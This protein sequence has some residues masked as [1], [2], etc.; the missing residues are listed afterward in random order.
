[1]DKKYRYLIVILLILA[2]LIA[3]GRI[4][5]NGFIDY[6]DPIYLTKNTHV[7][8]GLN[9]ESIQ[10]AFT[11]VVCSNWHPLTLLSHT[12]DWTLFK[13]NAGGHHLVSLFLHIGAVLLLFFFLYKTTKN[14]W[15][16]AFAAALF[17]LHPLRVESVAWAAERKDV[18]SIF[19]GLASIYAYASYAESRRLSRYLFCLVFFVLSLMSKPMLVTLPFL[20]LLIDYW[21][22]RR[23]QKVLNSAHQQAVNTD[24]LNPNPIKVSRRSISRLLWEKV[25]FIFLTIVSSMATLRAQSQAFP[26][27]LP[28][29]VRVVNAIIS[30]VSYLEKIFWPAD[31]AVFYPYKNAFLFMPAMFSLLFLIGITL[32]VVYY[33]KKMPFLFV[34]W[35]WYLGTLIPVIGLVQVGSQALADRYT[36]LPSVGIAMMLA[37]GIPFWVRGKDMRKKILFPAGMMILVILAFLTWQQ[38]GYWKNNFTLFKHALEVTE[39]NDL[40]HN[41]MGIAL[42]NEGKIDEAIGHYDRAIQIKPG[43]VDAYANRGNAYAKLGRYQRAIEDYNQ[44]ILLKPDFAEGYY[45]RGNIRSIL[46]QYQLALEDYDKAISLNPDYIKTYNNRGIIYG[47]LGQYQRAIEIFNTVIRL[48]PDYAYAYYNR[49]FAYA[50]LDQHEKAI[51]DFDRAI[52]LKSDYMKA[53]YNRGIAYAKL[54]RYRQATKDFQAVIRL[55]PDDENARQALR[56]A[57]EKQRRE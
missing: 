28:F 30:Y 34:G 21:P 35:F 14:I 19:F 1:M 51:D 7:K 3:F 13:D 42:L 45:S 46:G 24:M 29:P 44:A 26:I 52:S 22:L 49:G 39:D 31:L 16:S 33:F 32:G 53:Y 15:P 41:N 11:A 20:L 48:Q 50:R 55:R 10:W 2:S 54:G 47:E 37:W 18:L 9:P 5:G 23:W 6:D 4:A 36:Y 43:Y 25:P 38:C 27:H 8:S 40:A 57:L 56:L 17:A 12:L